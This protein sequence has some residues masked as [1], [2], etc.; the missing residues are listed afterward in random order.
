MKWRNWKK[1][2][3]FKQY[4]PFPPLFSALDYCFVIWELENH[5]CY[6]KIWLESHSSC[7]IREIREYI[8]RC[9]PQLRE[10][11]AQCVMVGRYRYVGKIKV[12][13][14]F[15][16]KQRFSSTQPQCCLNFSWIELQMLLRCC[17]I[18]I[19]ITILRYVI[20]ATIVSLSRRRST[21]VVSIWS[22]FHFIF[23]LIMINHI[24]LWI[25]AHLLCGVFCR[26]CRIIF[27]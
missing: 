10:S 9:L 19:G 18:H 3:I 21:Y 8:W 6:F 13:T 1:T 25:Q 23:I 2:L 15:F 4:S 14:R 22:I 16:Y 5:V 24:I 11:H 17:L 12:N 26:I 20:F 27:G 7:L